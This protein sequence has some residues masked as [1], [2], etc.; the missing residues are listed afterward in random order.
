MQHCQA[1]EKNA[2][3]LHKQVS[4]S[5]LYHNVLQFNSKPTK[6]LNL[7]ANLIFTVK[8]DSETPEMTSMSSETKTEKDK[9]NGS[10]KNKLLVIRF[11]TFEIENRIQKFYT[12]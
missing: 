7:F 6:I 3:S 1:K 9:K 2:H 12:F 5:L 11:D 4:Y 8:V 10:G